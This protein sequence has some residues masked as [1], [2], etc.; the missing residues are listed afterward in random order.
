MKHMIRWTFVVTCLC[1]LGASAAAQEARSSSSSRP[2]GFT[3]G[4]G[5]GWDIPT[6]IQNVNTASVRFRL[7]NG[8]TIEPRVDL[9]V[10]S[11]KDDFGMI[12]QEDGTSSFALEAIARWPMMGRGPVDFLA[13]GGAVID[14]FST[15][16]DGDD[17]NTTTTSLGLIY[18]L[19]VEYWWG[20]RWVFSFSATNPVF[21]RT[22][23]S[24]E[25]AMADDTSSTTS[26]FGAI[27]DPDIIA[28]FH[29]FY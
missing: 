2:D 27:W 1:A 12:T 16:P 22:K 24:R 10:T 7:A 13:L 21:G 18:G 20:P 9:S 4:M 6:D 5:A 28:M 17:N 26:G 23:I 29:L 11:D 14:V 8:L 3:V 15:D 25:V 19:S